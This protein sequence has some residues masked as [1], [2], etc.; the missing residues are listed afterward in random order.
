MQHFP[1]NKYAVIFFHT[2]T[3]AAP[4]LH[5]RP[6]QPTLSDHVAL[7]RWLVL[8]PKP[9]DTQPTHML[10]ALHTYA[11]SSS[12]Q[13]IFALIVTPD[14]PAQVLEEVFATNSQA[15]PHRQFGLPFD[16]HHGRGL[17]TRRLSRSRTAHARTRLLLLCCMHAIRVLQRAGNM[18][19]PCAFAR[20][21]TRAGSMT[22]VFGTPRDGASGG[23]LDGGGPVSRCEH[24]HG[25]A[26]AC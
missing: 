1:N 12:L 7:P 25:I 21:R 8:E 19:S 18:R 10:T 13:I 2:G 17:H 24:A 4:F 14:S 16:G 26:L 15:R 20:A 11:S 3:L 9:L 5:L 22:K 23:R 6:H